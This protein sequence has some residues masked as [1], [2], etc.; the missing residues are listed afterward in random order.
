MLKPVSKSNL[1]ACLADFQEDNRTRRLAVFL[2]WTLYR[3]KEL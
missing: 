2:Y 1:R 3:I